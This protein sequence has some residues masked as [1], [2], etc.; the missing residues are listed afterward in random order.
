[1]QKIFSQKRSRQTAEVGGASHKFG[2]GER[3]SPLLKAYDVFHVLFG[4]NG[5]IDDVHGGKSE[6]D[7]KGMEFRKQ[8]CVEMH[9]QDAALA[10]ALPLA[11]EL[12]LEEYKRP[13]AFRENVFHRGKDQPKGNKTQICRDDVDRLGKI[14]P[15]KVS[16]VGLIHDDDTGIGGKAG[17][18]L[19]FPDIDAVDFLR[20][21]L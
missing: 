11:L 8:F 6:P 10:D 5:R 15:M 7:G 17:V 20:A 1:M 12:R 13:P 2:N 3:R 14:F 16:G 4:A 18:E 19:A 21:V 9:G